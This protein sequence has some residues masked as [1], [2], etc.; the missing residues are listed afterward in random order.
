MEWKALPQAMNSLFPL[1]MFYS[2][3]TEAEVN[4]CGEDF[5]AR[6]FTSCDVTKLM[7]RNNLA[8]KLI[9]RAAA[10]V[11]GDKKGKK[12][13]ADL[14]IIIDDLELANL[15]QPAAVVAV[16]HEAAKRFIN[17]HKNESLRQKRYATALQNKVSFHFAKPMI[18][19]WLFA[20]LEGLSKACNYKGIA[21]LNPGRDPE[22]FLSDD[23]AYNA[24]SG[25]GCLCWHSLTDRKKKEH[26][27]QWLKTDQ[28]ELHPK[29][30]LSWLC[31]DPNEKK[32]SH[33]SETGSGVEALKSL[34]WTKLFQ[35]P[36]HACF[37]RSMIYDIATF[38]NEDDPFP[39]LT[40]Q[41]TMLQDC[42]DRVLRN[43]S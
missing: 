17:R 1:H 39:G 43:I 20:N 11:I 30:Y 25:A 3:P 5:P 4:S 40:A 26:R 35:N 22:C 29:A 8:D 21:R 2:L 36:N 15:H 14:V 19:S 7:G 9:E 23:L 24:D 32:C 28:R 6:S 13:A 37:A 33:Y 18:E 10:E 31:F 12:E 16:I 42:N 41:E 27:P 34:Q 38:L